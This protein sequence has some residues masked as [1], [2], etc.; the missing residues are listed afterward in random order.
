MKYKGYKI[1]KSPRKNKEYVAVSPS[2]KKVHFADPNMP[3][4]P[5]TKRGDNYCARSFGIGNLNNKS[6]ANFWSRQLWSCKG[7]KSVSKDPFFGKIS[8]LSKG[9]TKL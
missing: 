4:F 2:G 9:R 3:E 7:K 8:V 5:G 1:K 6:S